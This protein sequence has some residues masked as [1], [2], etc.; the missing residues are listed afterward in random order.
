M[1]IAVLKRTM[2]V[3]EGLTEVEEVKVAAFLV[4]SASLTLSHP[5]RFDIGCPES[6][7]GKIHFT[8]AEVKFGILGLKQ[9]AIRT[10]FTAMMWFDVFD[11]AFGFRGLRQV[12]FFFLQ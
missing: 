5:G 12:R 1:A 8:L 7:A 9:G 3:Y 10:S 11:S 4:E 6:D 2:T